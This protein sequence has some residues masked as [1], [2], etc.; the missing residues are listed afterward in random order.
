MAVCD[1]YGGTDRVYASSDVLVGE[2]GEEGGHSSDGID[3]AA[4]WGEAGAEGGIGCR[5][6]QTQ[7]LLRLGKHALARRGISECFERQNRISL[8]QVDYQCGWLFAFELSRDREDSG[9]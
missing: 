3:G 4:G 9:P 1:C 8:H 2:E 5:F 6:C 7:K